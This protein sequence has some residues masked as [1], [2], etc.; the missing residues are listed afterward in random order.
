[1]WV[2]EKL[3]CW[4]E[5]TMNSGKHFRHCASS[6]AITIFEDPVKAASKGK[7][8]CIIYLPKSVF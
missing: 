3:E 4:I 2:S 5:C 1:M 8:F 6:M 7:W